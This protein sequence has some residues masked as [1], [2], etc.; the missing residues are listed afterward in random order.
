MIE[1]LGSADGY[2]TESPERLHIDYAKNAYRASNRKEYLIQMTTWLS[3]QEALHTF[4]AY[5]VWLH[6][7][8]DLGPGAR[9]ERADDDAD[10]SEGGDEGTAQSGQAAERD[11]E[12]EE[13][14][15]H[16][17]LTNT[18]RFVAKKCPHANVHLEDI[19]SRYEATQFLPALNQY[20]QDIN[21]RARADDDDVFDLYNGMSVLLPD[22][23]ATDRP[24]RRQRIRTTPATAA[25]PGRKAIP[26]HLDTVLVK[27]PDANDI[28]EHTGLKGKY[29]MYL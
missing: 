25:R 8:G 10:G 24:E 3:R 12:D 21:V 9:S 5:L 22:L 20:L 23:P 27:T 16:N 18:H 4:A 26:A 29:S 2:N 14:V 13:Q 28:T 15:R 7:P 17:K 6:R 19:I 1:E 11:E